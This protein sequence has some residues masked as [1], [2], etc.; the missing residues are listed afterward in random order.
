MLRLVRVIMASNMA[1]CSCVVLIAMYK[2]HFQGSAQ[3]SAIA[4][5]GYKTVNEGHQLTP[6]F[7]SLVRP[8]VPPEYGSSNDRINNNMSIQELILELSTMFKAEDFDRL[9]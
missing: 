6:M 3:K 2:T 9:E 8:W 7:K 5:P 1:D 4:V